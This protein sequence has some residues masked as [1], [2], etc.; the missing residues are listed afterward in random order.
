MKAKE[1]VDKYY[2]NL[3]SKDEN[4][5]L[6]ASKELFKEFIIDEP[7]ALIQARNVKFDRGLIP[8]FKELN[9]KWLALGK[10]MEQKYGRPILKK[11][12]FRDFWVERIPEL[13]GKL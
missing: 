12:A 11:D 13:S 7:N 9:Q 3:T 6:A 8:I 4:I 10:Q 5:S 1:Y 2:E